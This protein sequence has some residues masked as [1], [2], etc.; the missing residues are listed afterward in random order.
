MAQ[1]PWSQG[2]VI[3][4]GGQR[5]RVPRGVGLPA[6]A[7]RIGLLAIA[8]LALLFTAYYQVEPEE[9]GVVQRFGR[10]V[11]T[12]GPGLHLKLPFGIETVTKVP[13]QRQ[14][15]K[16]FGFRTVRAGVRSEFAEPGRGT[17]RVGDAHRGPERRRR[18]VDR[19]VP[20]PRPEGVPLPRARRA[21]DLP[22]PLRGGR[23]AGRR[24]P[25][26]RRGHHG[27]PRTRSRSAATDGAAEALR[28][29]R[30][31][32]RGRAGGAPGRQPARPR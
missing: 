13:V 8:V 18:R 5:F 9:V 12:S 23:A 2:P 29:V 30:D 26:R 15:K 24:R 3:D 6:G 27:R 10:Y 1:P 14:L 31:R 22:R 28:P 11:R 4:I 17:G 16:E 21:R 19:A 20:H 32:H 25:H 7:L